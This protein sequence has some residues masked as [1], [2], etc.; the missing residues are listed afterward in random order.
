M[1]DLVVL[2]RATGLLFDGQSGFSRMAAYLGGQHRAGFGPCL[3]NGRQCDMSWLD[4][5]N[6]N[7]TE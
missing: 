3:G 2:A 5:V 1:A 7:V 4:E 6:K